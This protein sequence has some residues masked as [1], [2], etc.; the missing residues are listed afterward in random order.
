MT[1]CNN[2]VKILSSCSGKLDF[3]N[4]IGIKIVN[5]NEAWAISGCEHSVNNKIF[6]GLTGSSQ[7]LVFIDHNWINKR[8]SI[9]P[10]KR[11][12]RPKS[13]ILLVFTIEEI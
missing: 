12:T 5:L 4:T 10:F 7:A 9:S 2:A 1:A 8:L 3:Q 6:I 13:G 11:L